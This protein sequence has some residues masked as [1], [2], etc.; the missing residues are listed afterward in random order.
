M[1]GTIGHVIHC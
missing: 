1:D